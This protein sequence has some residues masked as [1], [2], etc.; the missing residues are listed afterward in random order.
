MTSSVVEPISELVASHVRKDA[1]IAADLFGQAQQRL[2][3]G[4]PAGRRVEPD[5]VVFEQSETVRIGSEEDRQGDVQRVLEIDEALIKR[6]RFGRVVS[7]S[8]LSV[9][10]VAIPTLEARPAA[11]SPTA[12]RAAFA[13]V[14]DARTTVFPARSVSSSPRRGRGAGSLSPVARSVSPPATSLFNTAGAR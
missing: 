13:V 11:S 2:L 5:S 1:L 9:V 10:G 12:G 14:L 7:H 4:V 6:P 3:A 8:K